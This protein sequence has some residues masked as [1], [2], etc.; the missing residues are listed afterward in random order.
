[1]RECYCLLS[2][3]IEW[4]HSISRGHQRLDHPNSFIE[5][6]TTFSGAL[7]PINRVFS[8]GTAPTTNPTIWNK[9][10]NMRNMECDLLEYEKS[11]RWGHTAATVGGANNSSTILWRVSFILSHKFIFLS[12]W[13]PPD[14]S[15]IS[16]ITYLS[17]KIL[18]L[19]HVL[20]ISSVVIWF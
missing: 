2:P 9:S 17:L 6:W 11:Y 20:Q 1:M 10:R 4:I 5:S 8:H 15:G 16:C 13:F 19:M 7:E 12:C 3:L 14:R 18:I